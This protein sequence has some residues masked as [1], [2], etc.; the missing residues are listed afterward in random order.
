M[1]RIEAA[2]SSWAVVISEEF[3]Q[4]DELAGLSFS[5]SFS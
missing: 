1:N 2:Q 3:S 4:L 5:W